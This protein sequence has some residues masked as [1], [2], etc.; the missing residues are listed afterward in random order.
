[1]P[2]G[3]PVSDRVSP[4]AA[5][6]EKKF[7]GKRDHSNRAHRVLACRPQPPM[8]DTLSARGCKIPRAGEQEVRSPSWIR[9][10]STDRMAF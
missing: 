9:L 5:P 6:T 10:L 3:L 1:M 8:T 4:L 7:N 2:S